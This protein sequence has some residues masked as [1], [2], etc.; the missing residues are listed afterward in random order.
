VN[1][2]ADR[3]T[4]ARVLLASNRGPLSFRFATEDDQEPPRL[5]GHRGGGGLVSALGVLESR[6][7]TVWVCAALSD[8]DR[9]AARTAPSGRIDLA[10]YDSDQPGN[11]G[12]RMLDIDR[13]VYDR[14]YNAV[15]NRTLWFVAHLLFDTAMSP[16]FGPA[17]GREWDAYRSYCAAFAEALAEE[18]AP[19]ATVV[20]Q[21]YHLALTPLLLRRHRPD[22]R[23]GHFTHTPWAPPDYFRMLPDHVARQLLSGMLGADRLCFLDERWAAAFR[24]C[25][26]DVLGAAIRGNDI[27]YEGRVSATG[28]HPLGVYA[29][30]LRNR[31][32]HADVVGRA[33]DLREWAGD[34]KILLRIDRTELSKNIVRGLE[35]Y[36]ELLRSRPQWRGRV[37]HLALCY[38]SR[39][40]LPEYREYTAAV[41]RLAAEIEDEFATS[42]WEP[43]RLEV[44]DDWARSLAAY[45]IADVL[46]VNPIRDGMNLVAKEGPVLSHRGLALVLSSQAGA[47][48]E[49]GRDALLINP[50]DVTETA[51]ALDAALS[52]ADEERASR[53]ARLAEAAGALPPQMWFDQQVRALA[54]VPASDPAH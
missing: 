40:D 30:D 6:E 25:C 54:T 37:V 42:T 24:A 23:I 22:L 29:A 43:L 53:C 21:D 4:K 15:A 38:P 17:F 16:S 44:S 27:E 7:P 13:V 9:H 32:T 47:A 50:F 14:A 11:T 52:M 20:I 12:V 31:A 36:R 19:G 10:G 41:Q 51:E 28:V 3:V 48:T 46:L 34:R 26:A 2:Y 8:A 5:I 33:D 39:H 49:L 18:A 45:G 1:Y 35:A